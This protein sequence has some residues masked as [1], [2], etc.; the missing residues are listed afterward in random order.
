MRKIKSKSITKGI[1]FKFPDDEDLRIKIKPFS[2]FLVVS[3]P[4]DLTTNQD[5]DP[6][7]LWKIFNNSI[8]DWEGYS[9]EDV[10]LE[11]N[12]EN[13]KMVFEYDHE[14]VA[15]V[16]EKSTGLRDTIVTPGELKNL[17]TSLDGGEIK[18]EKS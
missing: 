15:F 5:L 10:P 7:K 18:E 12:E 3:S 16:I 1:W 11:C 9:N 14:V 4:S 17:Q 8:V 6:D 2:L 13:K